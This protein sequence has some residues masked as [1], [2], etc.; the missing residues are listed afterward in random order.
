MN[1]PMKAIRQRVV[2]L[3]AGI[4]FL[5][6]IIWMITPYKKM[7]AGCFLGVCVSLYNVSHLAT[8]VKLAG[9]YAIATGSTRHKSTGMMHRYLMVAL[10][11]I[12][13]V[14]FPTWFDVRAIVAGLPV[15]YIMLRIL[16]LWE[17]TRQSSNGK[18]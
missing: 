6:L 16:G 9:N 3:T 5:L 11:I 15:C 13:A 10:A 2:F 7:V 1:D 4:L 12:I 18:G 8:R 14:S 17:V